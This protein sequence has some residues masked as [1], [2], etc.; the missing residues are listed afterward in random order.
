VLRLPFA[1]VETVGNDFVLF[2]DAPDIDWSAVAAAAGDRR[3][4]IGSD[5]ILVME[6]GDPLRLRMFNP[7]GSE[8]FCGNGLR[9]AALWA[10]E[11]GWS[12]G[13]GRIEQLGLICRFE[14][15]PDG[16]V[17]ALFPPAR[18]APEQAPCTVPLDQD[19]L[20][21]VEGVRGRPLNTG[22]THFVV[23]GPELPSEDDFQRLSPLIEVH[24]AFPERTTIM[25]TAL[26]SPRRLK[27]RIWERGAGE[28]LGCGT[29]SMAAALALSRSTG[30]AGRFEVAS[31][32]G[33]Q[34]V[35]FEDPFGPIWSTSA[36]AIRFT[37]SLDW[38]A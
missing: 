30:E 6:P 13:S 3:R 7:D 25:W 17:S 16:R 1:K 23:F 36:P 28:T 20:A 21:V 33:V 10:K 4:G 12:D 37:G 34:E 11:I 31:R 8:D 29:G 5:G 35:E 32:G 14:V 22:T 38:P 19:G 2:E 24:P 15:E 9:C 18:W 26:D 27:A